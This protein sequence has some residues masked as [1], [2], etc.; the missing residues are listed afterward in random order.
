MYLCLFGDQK[1]LFFLQI[2]MMFELNNIQ[3]GESF[4]DIFKDVERV[5]MPGVILTH[6]YN[7]TRHSYTI[8]MFL[9]AG[10]NDLAEIC[11]VL[12]A[13]KIDLSNLKNKKNFHMA[14]PGSSASIL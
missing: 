10:W 6:L 2:K 8:Y 12:Q 13:K 5:I 11:W 14:T 1:L 4:E 7:K 3:E 9:L